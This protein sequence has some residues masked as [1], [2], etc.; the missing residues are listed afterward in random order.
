MNQII[1]TP[2]L[3]EYRLSIPTCT[4]P[5]R[6][7][8][9]RLLSLPDSAVLPSFTALSGHPSFA[10]ICAGWNPGGLALAVSVT[11]KTHPPGG[12][13]SRPE[14]SDCFEVWLDT[15]PTGNVRRA[16]AYCHR[17]VC[18]PA[19]AVWFCNRLSDM[20]LLEELAQWFLGEF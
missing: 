10:E 7:K 15:R 12:N 11:G 9:G 6:R 16:T 20:D 13:R 2:L 8:T 5:A 14:N 18:F 1:P 4:P 3:F 17:L 19:E